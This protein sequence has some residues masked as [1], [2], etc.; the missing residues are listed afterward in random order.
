MKV[1]MV[2]LGNICRSPLAEGILQEKCKNL[3]L[4]WQVESAGTNGYHNGEPPHPQSQMVAKLNGIDISHQ[5]SRAFK[6]KDYD[7]F[8]LIIPMANDV[9]SDIKY[10]SRDKFSSTKTTLMLDFLFPG[11]SMDVPD[12]WSRSEAAYHEV[13]DLIDQACDKLIE[14]YTS[15]KQP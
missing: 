4:S 2:C 10:I 6:A 15:T 14:E 8:D 11:S 12:P 5:R 1:L 3:G 7:D 13:F 9:L